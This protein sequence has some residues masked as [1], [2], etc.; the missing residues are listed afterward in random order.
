[1]EHNRGRGRPPKPNPGDVIERAMR[2]INQRHIIWRVTNDF[3][4]N[5]D[6]Q[7][8]D[9]RVVEAEEA[10]HA[11]AVTL[12]DTL[13]RWCI[14]S[15]KQ[16]SKTALHSIR[17]DAKKYAQDAARTSLNRSGLPDSY[18][19]EVSID[20]TRAGEDTIKAQDV[21]NVL[22][23]NGSNIVF[24][25]KEQWDGWVGRNLGSPYK[26]LAYSVKE[27]DWTAIE[28]VKAL[29]N[30]VAHKSELS[31]QELNGQIARLV[32]DRSRYSDIIWTEK[33]VVKNQRGSRCGDLLLYTPAGCSNP[34]LDSIYARISGILK[35]L[36]I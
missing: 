29:R 33:R 22:C 7:L 18:K 26:R 17:S 1:M 15:V 30:N 21:E 6:E 25:C 13:S 11:L 36:Q 34:I 32:S 4:L 2:Q 14:A 12:E 19:L 3:L 10:L 23:P 20:V 24:A 16:N 5:G 9:A 35:S 8:R 27:E 31:R 28:Y